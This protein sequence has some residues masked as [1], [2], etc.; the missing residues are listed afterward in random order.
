M[1]RFFWKLFL[2]T[3][4]VTLVSILGVLWFAL[5]VVSD[6]QIRNTQSTLS[7]KSALIFDEVSKMVKYHDPELQFFCAKK[8]IKSGTRITVILADGRVI[9]DSEKNPLEMENHIN[10]VEVG[11]ALTGRAASSS[12]YSKTLKKYMVYYAV[13]ILDEMGEVIAILRLSF[14]Q[15]TIW[16]S[17]SI[18][19]LQILIAGLVIIILITLVSLFQSRRFTKPLLEIREGVK[20]ISNGHLNEKIPFSGI[21]EYDDLIS[22][23]SSM[24]SRIK[25]LNKGTDEQAQE[26]SAVIS[27]MGEGLIA[28]DHEDKIFYSN[29]HALSIFE[30]TDSNPAGKLLV[31]VFRNK[32]LIEV[33]KKVK[34]EK[35]P[36]V[37]MSEVRDGKY[38]Q[39]RGTG[40]DKGI[41]IV[42]TDVTE[43]NRLNRIRSEFIANASHELRT[44][45]T[46][47]KGFSEVLKTEA[48]DKEKFDHFLDRI[49]HNSNKLQS[50]IDDMLKLSEIE[51]C[52]QKKDIGT[53]RVNLNQILESSILS[54]KTHAEKKGIKILTDTP[55]DF[56]LEANPLL[57][58]IVFT[59]LI[60]NAVKYGGDGGE[61]KIK[62]DKLPNS[63]VK[64]SIKDFGG[65]IPV[66]E[67]E[68]IF[69]RFYRMN[70]HRKIQGTGLGLSIVKHIVMLHGGEIE[71]D[72]SVSKG[73]TFSVILRTV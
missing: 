24:S 68:K 36:V 15:S 69:E 56:F 50:L 33:A 44:P 66:D 13:P 21:S 47:I 4:L 57:I 37:L 48:L 49:S 2:P 40:F 17:I 55:D 20:K 30:I 8:G 59:N 3:F 64:V 39:I 5:A 27:S 7:Q 53:T 1:N 60:D 46:A 23:I 43:I 52:E 62:T 58:G 29:D 12:R 45:I 14:A 73:T 35:D 26:L 70:K 41:L 25:H 6:Y 65:G 54:Q 34:I 31:K 11:P 71:I 9:A 63:R 18:L 16:Q 38:I 28:I 32:Q 22:S 51:K 72:T 42:I 10:R 67:M 19:K 61:V